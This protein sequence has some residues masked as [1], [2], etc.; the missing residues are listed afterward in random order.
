MSFY[1]NSTK[2]FSIEAS[3]NSVRETLKE[4]IIFFVGIG[5]K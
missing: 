3:Y 5:A 4:F 2:D 1:E